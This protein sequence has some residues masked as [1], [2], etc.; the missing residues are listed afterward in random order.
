[1]PDVNLN[2]V[3]QVYFNWFAWFAYADFRQFN[4]LIT[5]ITQVSPYFNGKPITHCGVIA[6]IA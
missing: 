4:R 1:M 2:M 5:A 3:A 6:R